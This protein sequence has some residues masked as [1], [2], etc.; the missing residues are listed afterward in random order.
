MR[1]EEESARR[2]REIEA[3]RTRRE[4]ERVAREREVEQ[5]MDSMKTHMETLMKLVEAKAAKPASELSVKLVPLNEKDDIEAYLVTFERIMEAH[6]VPEDRWS[7]YVAPQLTGRAQ[8]AFAALP[9]ADSGKYSAIKAAILT[10]YDINEEAY[11]RRFRSATRLEGETN[12]ELTVRL[13]DLQLKWLKEYHT[14]EEVHEVLGMEQYLN[15][16]PLEKRVW[17]S[18]KKPKTC[19]QAGELADEYEQVRKQEPGVQ[20]EPPKKP[21]QERRPQKQCGY[22]GKLGHLKDECR[23]LKAKKEAGG[24]PET[25]WRNPIRCFQCKKE[26]HT[27]AS[28]PNTVLLCTE[29][30]GGGRGAQDGEPGVYRRGRVEGQVVPQI[31]LD[32]GC[33]RTMVKRS[34]VPKEKVP[35]G[36]AVTIRCAHGDTVLYPLADLELEIDGLPI[37]VEAAVSETL[38]VAV[39]LGRDVPELTQLLGAKDESQEPEEVMVVVTRAQARQ[40]LGEELLR[41]EREVISGAQPSPIQEELDG[42]SGEA[43]TRNKPTSAGETTQLTK[44]QRRTLRQQFGRQTEMEKEEEPSVPYSYSE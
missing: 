39:L 8:L 43:S 3:E 31:L 11:R 33:S 30:D 22:C 6:K 2:E 44:E 7:H 19:V 34:L 28:C 23:K 37:K 1:R 25:G 36:D 18:E 29:P 21:V 14:L 15:S 41:K 16:L 24:G 5:Q 10:R 9:T 40:Q 27:K 13:M 32:T 12:R 26:G 17:V 42:S 20:L 38:P 4:E 35:E